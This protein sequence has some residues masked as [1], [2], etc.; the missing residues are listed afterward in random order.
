[1]TRD[2]IKN[3][4]LRILCEIAP[5]ADPSQIKSNIGFREQLDIDSIDF[6]NFVIALNKQLGV[7]VPEADYPKLSTLD[8][9]V[10]YLAR[11]L[12]NHGLQN[13]RQKEGEI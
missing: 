4:T 7:E 9:C 3:T 5:E 1:M 13:H 11:A 6:L 12:R 2:E 8:G 10:E